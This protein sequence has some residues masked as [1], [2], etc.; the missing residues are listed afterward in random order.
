MIKIFFSSCL[1][2]RYNQNGKST[3]LLR[4]GGI[5]VRWKFCDSEKVSLVILVE[6]SK[7]RGLE[8]EGTMLKDLR[9]QMRAKMKRF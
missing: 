8:N 4:K 6:L 7:S 1:L 2:E 9:N 5:E 3:A